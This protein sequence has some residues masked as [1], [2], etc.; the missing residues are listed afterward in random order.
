MNSTF[1]K[2]GHHDECTT[3]CFSYDHWCQILIVLP[4][5]LILT[6]IELE[7]L[8]ALSLLTYP[9]LFG[10][11]PLWASIASLLLV[12]SLF[13]ILMVLLAPALH[14]SGFIFDFLGLH[15]SRCQT[16]LQEHQWNL[17]EVFCFDDRMF[18]FLLIFSYLQA[19]HAPASS[20]LT[21]SQCPLL[22]FVYLGS[23]YKHVR[24]LPFSILTSSFTMQTFKCRYMITPSSNFS[25]KNFLI[26]PT[27]YLEILWRSKNGL[28]AYNLFSIEFW[29][30]YTL[31]HFDQ[32]LSLFLFFHIKK[33]YLFI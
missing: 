3:K 5:S 25:L 19:H 27:N 26:Y 24:F 31:L 21:T 29:M 17:E 32:W 13:Y 23:S 4:Y 15:S 18:A 30:P 7:L 1:L 6:L 22:N 12:C 16:A 28:Q 10:K 9:F 14:T 33:P 20:Y 8:G 2:A 11:L